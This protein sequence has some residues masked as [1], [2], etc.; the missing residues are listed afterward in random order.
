MKIVIPGGSGQVGTVLA[1]HFHGSGHEVVVLSR[2]PAAKVAWRVVSWEVPS[3]KPEGFA[4]TRGAWEKELEGADVVV[5]LVGRSV[6]CRYTPANRRE[7][8]DSRVRSVQLVGDAIA[9]CA[10]PPRVWL[11]ASTATIYAHRYDAPNDERTG[12]LGGNEPN[13]PDTWNFS[14]EVATSWEKALSAVETPRTRKVA[15]RSAIVMNP[16]R[17]SAID[18]LLGLVRRRL[19]GRAGDGKQFV[20]WVHEADFIAALEFII[21]RDELSGAVN[22]AAPGPLPNADFMR[23]LREAWGVRF[24]LPAR[25]WMVELGAWLLRTE[26]ELILKSRYVVPGRLVDAGFCFR[27]PSWPEAVRDLCRQWRE[28]AQ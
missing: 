26:S 6:N 13:A 10:R 22:V 16:D 11:Q 18:V 24:G 4:Q 12:V 17:G 19:G 20:S 3:A 28:R 21:R 2:S 7:I 25:G 8:I 1:R 27:F 23:A 14:I 9:A 15:L 5:N